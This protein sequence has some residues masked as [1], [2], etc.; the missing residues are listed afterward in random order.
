MQTASLETLCMKCQNPFRGKIKRNVINLSSAAR[1]RPTEC[2][3][4]TNIRKFTFGYVPLAKTR[5]A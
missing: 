2:D 3:A 4:E 1:E 5:S